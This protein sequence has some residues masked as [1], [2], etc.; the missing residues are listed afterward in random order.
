M[1]EIAPGVKN[2]E[3]RFPQVSQE[4][5]IHLS[6]DVLEENIRDCSDLRCK[7]LVNKTRLPFITSDSPMVK[8]NQY[9]EQRE[10]LGNWTGYP[11]IGLQIFLPISPCM[12]LLLYD[13]WTYTIG[14]KKSKKEHF[15]EISDIEEIE[16]LNL[17]QV[18]NCE[19]VVFFN[20][21]IKENYI[22]ELFRRS[23]KYNKANES[24][25]QI[26][27][28]VSIKGRAKENTGDII[29]L[30]TSN[31][32]IQLN[33]AEFRLTKKAKKQIFD[34]KLIQIRSTLKR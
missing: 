2:I 4:T 13:N 20:E 31:S 28:G 5:A 7:L 11:I 26:M 32:S 25:V 30:S 21:H 29:S 8:Y 24:L 15:V 17:L 18:I 3:N 9:L 14:S 16:Q 10:W 22:R 19:L 6:F 27:K 33:I 23:K 1:K 12:I 34:N